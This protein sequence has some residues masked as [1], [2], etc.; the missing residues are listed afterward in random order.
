MAYSD[1]RDH[2]KKLEAAGLLRRIQR[3]INK[4]TEL[5]PLVRWQYR[6]GI[7]DEERKA[8]LFEN[9]TDA[10]GRRYKFPVAVGALAGNRAIYFLGMGCK[11]AEEMDQRWKEALSQPIAPV[12]VREAPCQEE[13]HA[14]AELDREG[15]G[16]EEFPVP[17]STPGFDN[18]PY[19]TCSHWFTKDPETGIQNVGNYRG[20][21]KARTRIGVFPSG[22][23]QDIYVHW[24]K[25]QAKGQPLPAALVIGA[26]PVVSYVSVQKVAYGVDEMAIAGA[27]AGEPIRAVKCK[28]VDL[29]VP[30]EA[31]IVVEGLL[32]TE[33]VEPE[34]PFGESHGYM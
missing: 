7:P 11:T 12:V 8:W 24:K 19:T 20:Q 30:A 25:A 34:G 13:V 27:L 26:P 32:N 15:M 18:G 2:L 9:V 14:G 23:G 33:W 28:T 3:L 16:L 31:E 10:R 17:I 5:H 29:F 22:L 21:V 1:L 6:G 4:D